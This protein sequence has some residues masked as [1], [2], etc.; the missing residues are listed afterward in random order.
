MY[1]P[2]VMTVSAT[3]DAPWLLLVFSLPAKRASERVG[4]WR[5]L[6]KY[7]ALPLKSSGYV[8]PQSPENLERFEWL[9]AAIRKNK[10]QASVVQVHS[11]DD[12]PSEKLTA[13]FID[14]R[15]RDYEALLREVK[16]LG[17]SGNS[18]LLLP[19][20]RRRFQEIAAIDFFNSPLRSR[21]EAQLARADSAGRMKPGPEG[22]R[23]RKE[24]LDRL[25]ITRPRPG[26]DRVSSAW[27]IR[28]FIDAN[29]K[30]VFA[31]NPASQDGAIPFDM[32]REDGFG[33]RGDDCTFETL[34][35]EFRIRDEQ[36]K[37]IAEVIHD[38]D[39]GDEKFG[40]MEGFGMDKI[41]IG[42]AQQGIAD[43]EILR[44]G[45][46]LVEGLYRALT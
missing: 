25:W 20:L 17:N 35:K 16:K 23:T 38:A 1:H 36:V 39:L 41:L 10:G 28:R 43:E 31:D 29:A 13:Q 44:R 27:L 22:R 7:G 33:H 18:A 42:W 37:K 21:A 12:L 24:Y 14:A 40:R 46:E 3:S 30:F 11:F 9:A 34:V 2:T 19:R 6:K 8:L 26:V 15:S 32:F 5:K 4:V 45:M